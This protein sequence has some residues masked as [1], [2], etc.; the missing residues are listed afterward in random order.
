M[1][2]RKGNE[3]KMILSP[4]YSDIMVA[5]PFWVIISVFSYLITGKVE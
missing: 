1:G 4:F 2:P 3:P 5:N